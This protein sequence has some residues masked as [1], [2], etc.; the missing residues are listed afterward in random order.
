MNPVYDQIGEGYTKHRCAD[1]RIVETL[2]D[3]LGISPPATIADI[4]AGT[5]NYSRAMADLG[6]QIEAIEPSDAMRRQAVSHAAVRWSDGTVEQVPLSDNS[7]DAVVCILAAHHFSSVSSAVAEMARVCGSGPIVW[8]TFD[9]REAGSPWLADYFPT[10]WHGA[11][12]AFPPLDDVCSQLAARANR[13]VE[14]LP[15]LIP[16]DLD[17]CF[18]A[19]GWRRPEMYLD[20]D[21]RACMSAFAL[22]DVEAVNQGLLRLQSDLETGK[23]RSSHGDLLSQDTVDWGYRFLKAT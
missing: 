21:V 7:V 14:V 23:W 8:L 11:F 5:G 15:F 12:S 22:A 1:R 20:P 10:I 17:D 3:L 19:A 9:P 16:H 2:A 4:G 18:M 6:F 13:Q